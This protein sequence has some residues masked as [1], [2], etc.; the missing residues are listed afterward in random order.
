VSS[1]NIIKR[2]YVVYF[3]ILLF[4]IA[5]VARASLIMFTEGEF[6]K[7]KAA[8][9]TLKYRQ[10]E[11]VRG[12]IYATN[13]SLLATSIPRYEIRFDCK[14][15]ALTDKKFNAEIDS[16][17]YRLS[18]LFPNKSKG[19]WKD[20]LVGARERGARYHLIARRV[21]YIDLKKLK[22]F[23]IFRKGRYKGGFMYIQ[24]NRRE[25]PFQVLASRTIGYSRDEAKPVG[26]EGA[27]NKELSGVS[28]MRLMQKIAGG[29]WMPVNDDNEIEPEDGADIV[30]TLNI[31]IQDVAENALLEQL[32]KQDAHHGCVVLMEVKT[33]EIKAIANLTRT[34][35]GKYWERYNYAVGESTEPGSTFKLASLIA[36]MEDG[37]ID[38]DD[39]VKTGK[40][41]YKFYDQKMYDSHAGGFGTI[42]VKRAFEVS[43]NIA[44]A[45]LIN[46][47]YSKNP[48][49]F[50]DRLYKMNL[51]QKLGL[52]IFGEGLPNIKSANDPTWSGISLPWISHGYEVA[53]TPLQ[54]LTY[55]NAV[56]N[57]G[58][59]VKPHFVREIR[60]MGKTVQVIQPEVINPAICSKETIKKAKLMLEGV[61]ENGTGVNLKNSNYK[62]AG[63]TGTAQIYNAKY[64][65]KSDKKVS[66]QASFVGYFPAD[67]PKYSCIVVVNA[68]SRDVY[69]GNLVAG[70]IFKEIADKVYATSIN[71]HKE[72]ETNKQLTSRTP[73]PISKNG[74]Y[75]DLTTVFKQL[76]ITENWKS[77]PGTWAI[78]SAENDKVS[79]YRR[80]IKNHLIPNVVGMD[81]KDAIF[82]M[83]N[84]GIQIE[85]EGKGVI[86]EQIPKAGSLINGAEVV[87]LKLA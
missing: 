71:I 23:P 13:G 66:Y 45:K 87:K 58:V 27:Y 49:K 39:S 11:A 60:K 65:Y 84:M 28:G 1:K 73:I 70:P 72:L 16:L 35:S 46:E 30:S 14:A 82:I 21:N 75:N 32:T 24:K 5:I 19:K 80:S 6:W 44:V 2:I 54:I 38:L 79:L 33:G 34:E 52:E 50:I 86:K 74:N 59:M 22:S 4:A 69:Y 81:L 77:D 83:E 57:D 43:S 31:N 36:A 41:V 29:V 10:I 78:T 15:D 26:L 64:G 42:T 20:E 40:G 18:E 55:Y 47:N 8:D 3:G 51:N 76:D 62:I 17:C 12:N 7:Q 48:Q 37:Y 53:L 85:F 63:K 68:P 61:V 9:H 56:A 25:K 67:A